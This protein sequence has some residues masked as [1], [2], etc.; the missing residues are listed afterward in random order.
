MFG[1]DPKP[2]KDAVESALLTSFRTPHGLLA[3]AQNQH[4]D[5][6]DHAI[7]DLISWDMP[8]LVPGPAVA[9]PLIGVVTASVG[10][11]AVHSM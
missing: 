9:G 5:L 7:R 4:H 6:S 10:D 8:C 11:S 2:R 1:S 3:R